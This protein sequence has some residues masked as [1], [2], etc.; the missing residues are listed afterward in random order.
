MTLRWLSQ[1]WPRSPQFVALLN[2]HARLVLSLKSLR[3][4]GGGLQ[5]DV[6][7]LTAALN[8]VRARH[9]DL[10]QIAQE[11]GDPGILPSTDW[12][13]RARMRAKRIFTTP[14]RLGALRRGEPTRARDG[15]DARPRVGPVRPR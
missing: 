12:V 6:Q 10:P 4:W 5:L 1:L 13:R 9:D 7:A 14:K 11:V 15:L 3:P 8:D 2:S